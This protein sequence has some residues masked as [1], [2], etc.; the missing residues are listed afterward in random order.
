MPILDLPLFHP[1]LFQTIDPWL[2]SMITLGLGIV[3]A[4]VLDGLV[5]GFFA[6]LAKKT[7]WRFDDILVKCLKGV[8]FWFV[9]IL[10]LQATLLALPPHLSTVINPKLPGMI[11]QALTVTS[12]VLLFWVLADTT[13]R[14]LQEFNQDIHLLPSTSIVMMIARMLIMSVG[15]LVALQTLGISV[16][17][18][19]TALG[20]GG[21]A[22]SLALK[23]TLENVFAGLQ[24]IFSRQIRLGDYIRL[25]NGQEGYA[26]D[27]GWRNTVIKQ[28]SDNLLIVPNNK[29]ATNMVINFSQ[30][31]T[32]MSVSVPCTVAFTNDL[33]RVEAIAL[34]VATD[35]LKDIETVVSEFTPKVRFSEYTDLG[36]RFKV[37]FQVQNYSSQYT[38]THEFIKRLHHAFAENG[39]R[40]AN[41][42]TASTQ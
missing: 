18:I 4:I 3:A 2:P 40:L 37:M 29:L 20:I 26:T 33:V 13:V 28:A 25:E 15:V 31:G 22:I 23:D 34:A 14:L 11:H 41:S 5:L 7:V 24:I 36:V 21:L 9:M 8:T 6:R 39:I 30:P 32:R 17:P 12:I 10:T 38:L 19:I 35:V 16:L 42:E 1:P 27:I